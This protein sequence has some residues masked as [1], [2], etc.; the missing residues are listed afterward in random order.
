MPAVEDTQESYGIHEVFAG[1]DPIIDI[2]AVHGLNGHPFKSW[3]TRGEEGS[4]QRCWLSD[5]DLLPRALKQAR[6]LTWGY[7][8]NVTALL[9]A[10]SSDRILNHAQTLVAQLEADRSLENAS[11][12]PVVFVCHSL[13][14]IIVKK[15]L[16]YSASR[17]SKHIKHLH[18][19]YV[20]TYAILFLGT[21]HNGSDKVKLAGIGQRMLS[22]LAP[23][24]VWDTNNQ[25]LNALEEGS[26]TLQNITDQF[27]PLMKQFRIYFFWEQEKTDLGYTKDYVVDES[28][29]API[30]DN[31]ERSGI[32]ACHSEMCKFAGKHSPGYKL[33]VAALIRYSREASSVIT[34]RWQEAEAMLRTRRAIEAEELV[35]DY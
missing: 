10:T 31:I 8:A 27:A 30:L 15:A 12:R 22:A 4:Q 7:N 32:P 24:K 3:T 20:S 28:S 16:A 14:G 11:R 13:G 33:V 5:Q 18:S 23:K 29:A 9:G 1:E 2:V 35:R 6:I 17:T 25:L 34:F 26:E 19:I 21:P